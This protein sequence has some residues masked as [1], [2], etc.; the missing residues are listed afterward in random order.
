MTTLKCLF[1]FITYEGSVDIYNVHVCFWKDRLQ[2]QSSQNIMA[3]ILA[4]DI[5]DK[6]L[7]IWGKSG[8][9]FIS[10]LILVQ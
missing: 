9:H 6:F 8:F 1:L 2:V 10:F 5:S 3:E 4:A 7:W